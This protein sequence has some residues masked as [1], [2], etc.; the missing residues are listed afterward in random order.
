MLFIFGILSDIPPTAIL[1]STENTFFPA[2]RAVQ[3]Q[4]WPAT[5]WHW[6]SIWNNHP[7]YLLWISIKPLDYQ[8]QVKSWVKN[9]DSC[10]REPSSDGQFWGSPRVGV[11]VGLWLTLTHERNNTSRLNLWPSECMPHTAQQCK[12]QSW[13]YHLYEQC[14]YMDGWMYGW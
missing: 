13:S 9:S 4:E 12:R 10:S 7:I 11:G 14:I 1:I 6:P 5:L 2:G 8:R 3:L